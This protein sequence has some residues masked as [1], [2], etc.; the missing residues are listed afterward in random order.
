MSSALPTL[1]SRTP[2]TSPNTPP[3][4]SQ[5]SKPQRVL[6]CVL[7]QQRKVRCECVPAT[8]APR[9]PKR[10]S[11]QRV[12]LERLRKYESLLRQNNIAF[13]PLF[14]NSA[15]EKESLNG[16]SGDDSE[17]E[18]RE[19]AIS[20]KS[21]GLEAKNIWHVMSQA[22]RDPDNDS[23]SSYDD[24]REKVVKTAWEH[25][26]T[27]ND[28][29]FFGL[30]RT[31]IDLS[32]LHPDPVQIFKIWQIY[33]DN[34]NPLLK[35][36]HTP[37]LQG[38]IIQ[39][40]ISIVS[41]RPSTVPQSLSSLLGIGFRIA[42]R[43]GI[44]SES[45]LA[46]CTVIEAEMRRRLWWSLVLFDYR[47]SEISNSKPCML[48]PTWDCKIPLN[49]NDSDLR[50]DMKVLPMVQGIS[51]EALFVVVRS[52]LGDLIRHTRYHLDFT[53][54]ALKPLAKQL[55]STPIPEGDELRKL[56]EKIESQYL[57]F[58]DQENPIHFMAIW[59]TRAHLAKCRLMEHQM[60][61]SVSPVRRTE[62]QHDA[63]TSYAL[64]MLECD[65]MIMA[66]PLAERFNWLNHFHFPFPGYMQVMQD[67]KRRP[68]SKQAPKAWEVM[69]DNY[70]AWLDE[71]FRDDNPF[72]RMFSK[73]IFETWDACEAALKQSGELFKL[74]RIVSTMRN[75]LAEPG[76]RNPHNEQPNMATDMRG[77][78][79]P[80]SIDFADE[81]FMGMQYGTAVMDPDLF[82][83]I[84][85]PAPLDADM[86][87]IDWSMLG[88][89]LDLGEF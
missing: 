10:K 79:L 84:S 85:G 87:Q 41:I 18:P 48:D 57:Q 45:A 12:L 62:A 56:E 68:L 69:S 9:R 66:S 44:H 51:S 61:L 52:D 34:V 82:P 32:T 38:R 58:C 37:S 19:T 46:K 31:T 75:I 11:P 4:S 63:A 14:K 88:A 20:D 1:E 29:P 73:M 65:T 26:I 71:R 64:R 30:S 42:Q 7:C 36:T 43:M 78:E 13:D 55:P 47:L 70:T 72:F 22:F 59:T 35:V 16:E 89:R 5:R 8:L 2:E 77:D 54:P 28:S 80:M 23:D 24:V 86:E 67:I 3:P 33:L 39:A 83:G 21:A 15:A 40:T 49:V 50:A 81:S 17:D 6:A 27:L 25:S 60:R 53:N 74:P 76:R